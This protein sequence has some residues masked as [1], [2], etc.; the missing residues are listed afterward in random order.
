MVP[1]DPFR[2]Y[3]TVL[4]TSLPDAVRVLDAF[5]VIPVRHE[6][7]CVRGRVRGPPRRP[8]AAGR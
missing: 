6:A 3:A 7:P 4:G 5:H 8:V 1:L 2:G